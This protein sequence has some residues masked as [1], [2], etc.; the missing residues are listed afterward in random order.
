M[1]GPG[2]TPVSNQPA[3]APSVPAEVGPSGEAGT[4]PKW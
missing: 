4:C 1:G 2:E 3:L